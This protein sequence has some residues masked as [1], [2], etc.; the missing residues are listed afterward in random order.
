MEQLDYLNL[1]NN[2]IT[3]VAPLSNLKNVTYLTLA[4]NHILIINW[5]IRFRIS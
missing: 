4:G 5:I 3:N 2:K 1:A